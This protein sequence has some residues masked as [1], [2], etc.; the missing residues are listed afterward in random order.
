MTLVE[1][2]VSVAIGLVLV[3]AMLVLFAN[4]SSTQSELEKSSRQIENGRYAMQLLRGDIEL[5]GYWG[6]Y[7]PPAGATMTVPADPCDL[8]VATQGWN[9]ATPGV[10]VALHG[11]D[12]A[13][14]APSC[15]S[16]RKSGTAVLVLRRVETTPLAA[17][18]AV[19]GTAY[20]QASLCSSDTARFVFGTGGFTLRQK[21]CA[22]LAPVRKYVVRIYYV[23]TC[24]V[25]GQD[26]IPTLKMVENGGSPQP[27]VEGIENMQFDYGIDASD[28]GAPDSYSAAPGAADWAHVMTLRLHLLAR[29][30]D[31]SPG[32]QD[33]KTYSLGL[34]GTVTPAG[35]D[36]QFKRHVFSQA[37]RVVN[38]SARR[39]Q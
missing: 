7:A 5:A 3:S 18:S 37:V 33:N 39:D 38:V 27:L 4:Q 17:A 23:S 11:Y 10:P 36:A 13:A 32:Y 15:L 9:P 30:N 19:A 28:D 20:L 35:G 14:A 22:T 34:S 12:G 8:T 21:D 31:K 26:T 29:N 2:M 1:W 6:E 16:N 24:S 25:C